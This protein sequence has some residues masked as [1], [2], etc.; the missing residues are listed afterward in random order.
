VNGLR[1]GELA[2]ALAGE[3]VGTVITKEV[4]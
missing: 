4:A 2:R 3:D 1:P